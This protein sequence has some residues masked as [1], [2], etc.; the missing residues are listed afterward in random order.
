[1]S[2]IFVSN[3][4]TLDGIF[5]GPG[6]DTGWFTSDEELMHYNLG[7]L[8][9]ADT[10]LMGR[11]T[12]DLMAGY[13]PGAQAR[14]DFAGAYQF[15]N[16]SRKHIFSKTLTESDWQRCIFHHE[17]TPE[18][19]N[20]IK[21]STSKDIVILGSGDLSMQLHKLGLID[22]YHILLDPQIKSEGRKFFDDMQ[23]SKLKLK[24][25]KKFECGVAY[26]QYAVVK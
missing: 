15:M 21:D 9:E 6:G 18:V 26:L 17:I 8:N 2:S 20:N 13:W 16:E 4:V 12:Y 24:S 22:E 5:S 10:I 23:M 1:M 25:I 14:H 7:R 3:W 11:I 19:I